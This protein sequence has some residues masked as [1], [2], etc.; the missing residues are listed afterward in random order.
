MLFCP[1]DPLHTE[2]PPHDSYLT[3]LRAKWSRSSSYKNKKNEMKTEYDFTN[4]YHVVSK[5]YFYTGGRKITRR[6]YSF[7]G[8][9]TRRR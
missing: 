9:S 4:D 8:A 3:L 1:A 7:G 2:L 6:S 5:S